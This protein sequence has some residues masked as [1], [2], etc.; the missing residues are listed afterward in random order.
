M[1]I[2]EGL[3]RIEL[4]GIS[5]HGHHGLFDFERENGQLFI[6]DVTLGLDLE[7]A[8]RDG[9]LTKS[10]HYGELAQAVHDAIVTDPVDLI[11]TLALRI[12]DMCLSCLLYTSP[13][14]RDR[15]RYRMPYSA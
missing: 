6:V 11:E 8:A 5:A 9:D 3:D 12:A 15:T 10:V 14:P 2:P 7:P 4:R 13:S 1:T